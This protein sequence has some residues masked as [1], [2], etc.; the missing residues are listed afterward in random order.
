[1][2]QCRTQVLVEETCY[3]GLMHLTRTIP[4]ATTTRQEYDMYMLKIPH[5][6]SEAHQ[7]MI[8]CYKEVTREDIDLCN[9]VP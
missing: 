9:A 1:M 5:A 3:T 6:T 7:S 4:S 2:C 8:N